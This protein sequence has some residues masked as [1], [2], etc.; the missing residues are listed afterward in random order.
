MCIFAVLFV[1]HDKR[2]TNK[3]DITNDNLMK[4][5]QHASHWG[6]V[7]LAV[8]SAL[9]LTACAADGYDDDE[10]FDSSVKGTQLSSPGEETIT[11]TPSADGKTQTISWPV[12]HGA[13]GYL[14]SFYDQSQPE[15]PLVSDSLIDGCSVTV[16]RQEDTNYMVSV[17]TV[18]NSKIKNSDAQQAT[19]LLFNTFAKELAT[20]PTGADLAEWFRQNPIPDSTEAIYYNLE[21]EGHYTLNDTLDLGGHHVVL[22]TTDKQNRA[23]ITYGTGGYFCTSAPMTLQNINLDCS[24]VSDEAKNSAAI[25]LSPTPDES[26]KGIIN[27]GK[28]TSSYYNIAV[29]PIYIVNCDFT[30]VKGMLFYDNNKQYCVETLIIENC[31]VQ[32]ITKSNISNWAYFYT[33]GGF[34]KDL[35]IKNSSMWNIGEGNLQYVIR[36]N[37]SGRLDRAGYDRDG[38]TQSV[39]LLSSTFYKL[40]SGWFCNWAAFAGQK[41]TSFDIEKNIFCECGTGGN[42]IARRLL[43][44]RPA[45][46]YGS[47]VFD[48]N[49][50]WANGAAEKEGAPEDE[51]PENPSQYDT[52]HSALQSDPALSDPAN[53]DLTPTGAEQLQHKTGDPRWLL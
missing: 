2:K 33:P 4:K 41:Y 9:F 50:Y 5:A 22:R 6:H 14:F 23:Q 18:G 30:G 38:E 7:A 20:V 17:K 19:V 45:S 39:S 27:H 13:S 42:G 46:A 43:A 53:G 11:V 1:T 49:T 48:R 21:P 15:A 35:T 10:R 26:I 31:K 36:Y 51:D 25:A 44:T 12:V 28:Y 29:K 47:V 52:S 24:G 16:P 32:F 37:N 40:G 8:A 3:S 34:I